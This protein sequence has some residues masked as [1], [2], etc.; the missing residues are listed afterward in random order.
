VPL[1]GVLKVLFRDLGVK[2]FKNTQSLVRMNVSLK[3]VH[4]FFNVPDIG[5]YHIREVKINNLFELKTL[6][7]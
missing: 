7:P 6:M 5:N 1:N 4:F 3:I 2:S